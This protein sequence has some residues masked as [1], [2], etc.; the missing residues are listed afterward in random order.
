MTDFVPLLNSAGFTVLRYEETSGWRERVLATYR[1]VLD[2]QEPL[3]NELG[4]PAY[5]ALATEMALTLERDFYRR[6]VLAV[7][8]LA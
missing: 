8:V 3:S 2:G 7:S 5:L 6:R 4:L 1:A